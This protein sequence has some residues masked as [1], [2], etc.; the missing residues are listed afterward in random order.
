MAKKTSNERR[1]FGLHAVELLL[2]HKPECIKCLWVAEQR[3]DARFQAC[4]QLVRDAGIT[5]HRVERSMLDQYAEGGA[6]QGIVAACLP[7]LTYTESDLPDLLKVDK[8]LFILVLD[9]VQ[10]PHNVGACLR[11]ANAFAVDFVLMPQDRACGITPVVEKVA[12]G[13]ASLTPVVMVK[14]LARALALMKEAG[15]WCVGT[16][17]DA[18]KHL[19][20]V[21]MTGSIAVIM[22]SEE[23]GI[24]ALTAKHCDFLATI[25]MSGRMASLN[26]SVATGIALYQAH[27]QRLAT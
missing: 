23:K 16:V 11:S 26:V 10:D 27:Q 22:G 7:V 15:V 14:N 1:V 25:P 5:V 6:H 20:E 4:M 12:C 17:M 3:D 24:R 13:A 21:D 19:A 2:V 9:G 8:P 18:P